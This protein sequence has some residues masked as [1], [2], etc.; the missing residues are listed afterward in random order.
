MEQ[1][2][3]M[4]NLLTSQVQAQLSNIEKADA[5]ELGAAVDMIKDI[6]ETMYYCSVVEA[7]EKAEKEQEKNGNQ[8]YYTERYYPMYM[9]K[10]LSDGRYAEDRDGDG[11]H[12][13]SR[14]IDDGTRYR[15]I[16]YYD[17]NEPVARDLREGR[18]PRSRKMYMEAK[19][20]HET[21]EV[22]MQELEK[23]MGELSKDITEMIG[24]ASPEE[25]QMLRQKLQTL[26]QKIEQL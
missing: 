3:S 8:V 25:K 21:K 7:M 14:Y 13:E 18:S 6:S 24:D 17:F 11:R 5:N 19:E 22:K 16:P 15:Y 23:Y 4:K 12:N 2:K 20:H 10:K 9:D 26:T 1:L